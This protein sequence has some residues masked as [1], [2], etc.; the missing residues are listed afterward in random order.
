MVDSPAKTIETNV[1]CTWVVLNASAKKGKRVIIASTSEVYGKYNKFPFS[2]D[3]DLSYEGQATDG[4]WS[5]ACSKA[6]DEFLAIAYHIEKA[7]DRDRDP[8]LN[9]VRNCQELIQSL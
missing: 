4:W 9:M 2:E 5:Y 7:N 8:L 1:H 6:L 3:A